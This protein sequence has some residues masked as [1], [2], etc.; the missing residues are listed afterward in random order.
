M[1]SFIC[2]LVLLLGHCYIY[3]I[4]AVM[5]VGMDII[6]SIGRAVILVLMYIKALKTDIIVFIGNTIICLT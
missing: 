1:G 4:M 2:C 3:R 5:K 6:T